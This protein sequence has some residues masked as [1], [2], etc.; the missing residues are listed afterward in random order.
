MP[1]LSMECDAIPAAFGHGIG[2]SCRRRQNEKRKVVSGGVVQF[3]LESI[4]IHFIPLVDEMTPEEIDGTWYDSS[5]YKRIK[6]VNR[7]LVNIMRSEG[8]RTDDDERNNLDELYCFR[9]L[10]SRLEKE[11]EGR[12]RRR[13]QTAQIIFLEQ[14]REFYGGVKDPERIRE[15]L[16]PYTREALDDAM[17]RGKEDELAA[18]ESEIADSKLSLAGFRLLPVPFVEHPLV[19]S[20]LK[21]FLSSS[22]GLRSL[23]QTVRKTNVAGPNRN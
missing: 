5:E 8:C 12:H 13:N 23:V 2:E 9:G 19:T 15:L 21:K 1:P 20:H 22:R 18:L 7:R 4:H 11:R 6:T 16:E 14:Q 10:E 3:D 17:A